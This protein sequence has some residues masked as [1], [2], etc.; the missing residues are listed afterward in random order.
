MRV[1]FLHPD[2]GIGGAERLVLDAA[3]SLQKQGVVVSF[4]TAHHDVNHCF[5]ETKDGTLEVNCYG[6]FLPRHTF[7]RFFAFWAYFRMVYVS[8]VMI[9]KHY[10]V[11]KYD[12]VFIDQ[13]SIPVCLFRLFTP[14]KILFYCHF[15]DKLLTE[16]KC[17]LKKLYRWPLD[18]LEELTTGCAHEVLVNSKFTAGVFK[19]HFSLLKFVPKVLYPAINLEA[20]DFDHVSPDSLPPELQGRPLIV[21]LNRYERKKNIGLA[22]LAFE[23]VLRDPAIPAKVRESLVLVIAGGYDPRVAENTEHYCELEDLA[24][25]QLRLPKGQ[26]AFLRS[27]SEE[28]RTALLSQALALTY[29]PVNEHFGIVPCEAMYAQVPVV[30][31]NSGGPLE[32]VLEGSTGFLCDPTPAA[33]AAALKKLVGDQSLQQQMATAAKT[34]VERQFSLT[35]FGAALHGILGDLMRQ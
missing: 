35:A 24:F 1:G 13:V 34:H 6:D 17:L 9:F 8:I 5:T 29:T 26:V 23:Q 2:L 22:L 11:E 15:P 21:S 12:C 10:F 25:T 32:S 33:F 4:D 20:W 3:L 30:A 31:C 27:I 28:C 18:L 16:R 19:K 14:C 7:G